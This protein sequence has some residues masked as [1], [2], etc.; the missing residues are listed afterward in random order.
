[1]HGRSLPPAGRELSREF[2]EALAGWRWD[3]ALLQEVPPWWPAL[4]GSRLAAS[5]RSVLTSRNSLPGVRRFVATRWPDLIKSNGGGCN[6]ILVRGASIVEHRS[7][8]LCWLPER[9]WV[10]AVRLESGVWVG[11]LHG[12]GTLRECT[13]AG[14][15]VR[16]LAGD[17]PAVLGGDFNVRF[18]PVPG[19]A[20]T[21]GVKSDH[22]LASGL[23]SAGYGMRV[24]EQGTLSDHAP[25]VVGLGEL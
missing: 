21:G 6:A 8:R 14:R 17:A 5:A 22:V 4:L 7:A 3:V 1:M 19:F 13:R 12:G 9:R 10:H 15:F 2:G 16:G 25:V 18:P 11:N 24:L 20:W 23:S